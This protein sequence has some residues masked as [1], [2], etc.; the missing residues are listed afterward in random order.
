MPLVYI[1][2]PKIIHI[3]YMT[4]Y[5]E[6]AKIVYFYKWSSF[7]FDHN[8]DYLYMSRYWPND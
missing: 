3:L 1:T 5:K 2:I 8:I 4:G 7:Y 6:M